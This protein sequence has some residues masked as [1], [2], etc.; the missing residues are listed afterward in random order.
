MCENP[1]CSQILICYNSERQV[2]VHEE[3]IPDI[4]SFLH[5][6]PAEAQYVTQCRPLSLEVRQNTYQAPLL[7]LW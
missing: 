2:F 7:L 6:H 5:P 3:G 4:H 1:P